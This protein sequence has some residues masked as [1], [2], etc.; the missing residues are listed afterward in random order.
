M[1]QALLMS[2]SIRSVLSGGAANRVERAQV[3]ALD[4]HV[5]VRGDGPDAGDGVGSLV[6]APHGEH[7]RRPVLG[8]RPCGLEAKP[9]VGAGHDAHPPAL[10]RY[11]PLSPPIRDHHAVLATTLPT[12]GS[13]PRIAC[14][15]LPVRAMR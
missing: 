13:Y 1:I 2:R 8:E 5:D 3:E 6:G 15:T 14:K 7:Y 9:G 10:V 4:A 11:V 12:I